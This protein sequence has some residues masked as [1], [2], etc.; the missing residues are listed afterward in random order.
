M[1]KK[2]TL[3][4]YLQGLSKD[5]LITLLATQIENDKVLTKQW[6]ARLQVQSA[7]QKGKSPVNELKKQITKAL[8]KK[9][10]L[11]QRNLGSKVNQYFANAVEQ[12]AFIDQLLEELNE[13]EEPITTEQHFTLT[14]HAFERLNL[15]LQTI[16]D[17][18]GY[19]FELE[20]KLSEQLI[21]LFHKLPWDNAK[22]ANWLVA[23]LDNG[24]DVF[25][26]IPDHFQLEAALR[27]EFEQVS[28][29]AQQKLVDKVD[30][31][32]SLVNVKR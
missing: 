18:W 12:F 9:E 14:C 8:P 1:T 24:L 15:V 6:Q 5:Q 26:W 2:L 22:K 13:S 31:V 21:A 11:M 4:S 10:L 3:D 7:I 30:N 29:K 25:P 16:D 20:E 32:V 23:E 17:S 27:A 19:R 28:V